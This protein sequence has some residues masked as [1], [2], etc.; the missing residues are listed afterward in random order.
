MHD[1]VTKQTLTV[2]VTGDAN[3]DG[4]ITASDYVNVKFDV[5]GKTKLNGAYSVAADINGDGKITATDYV[6]IKF[7]VL[8][9]SSI[10]PR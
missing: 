1:G 8:N 10:K 4:K 3:G 7:H 6:N 5:L 2:V 9:K